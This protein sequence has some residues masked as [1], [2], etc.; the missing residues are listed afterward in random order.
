MWRRFDAA[1]QNGQD[2]ATEGRGVQSIEVGARILEAI[3][4]ASDPAMLRDIARDAGVA[5]AQAHAYLVSYRRCNLVEQDDL[6]GRYRLGPLALQ[7]GLARLRSYDPLKAAGEAASQFASDTGLSVAITVWGAYGPTIVQM[8]EGS[9]QIHTALRPGAVFSLSG[10]ATGRVF[11]ANL[12]KILVN[13]GMKAQK[14][15]RSNSRFIGSVLALSSIRAELQLIREQGYATVSSNPIPDIS[16]ISA[17]IFETGGELTGAITIV[18]PAGSLNFDPTAH[19][20]KETV[21]LAN[22]ISARAGFQRRDLRA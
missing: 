20:V 4:A 19:L 2:V 12:P 22:A 10:T 11:C 21:A 16:A 17:P 9:D 15:E 8:H 3:A 18:G 6:T 5:S 14:A 1:L 13:E 7:L